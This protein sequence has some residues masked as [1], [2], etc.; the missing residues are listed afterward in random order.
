[1]FNR[2]ILNRIYPEVNN[3]LRPNQNGFRSRHTTVGHILALRRIIE[4]VKA[5]NLPAILTFV[6]F[7]KAF[8]TIHRGKMLQILIAYGIPQQLVDA[9]EILYRNTQAKV[10]S[11]DGETDIF[12][13]QA[14]V[15]QGDTLAPFIFIIVL[16][17]ALRE[18]T[19]GKEEELGFQ[20]MKRKSKRHGPECITDLDF[21][22]DISLLSES[23]NQAQ[24]LLTRLEV[25]SAKVGLHLNAAKT[26][27]IAYNQVD[28]VNIK[29][30]D[31]TT[32]D[33]TDDFKYLGSYVDSTVKEIN[34]RKAQAWTACHQLRKIWNSKMSKRLKL[35]LFTAAVESVLLYGCE[36]W[37]LNKTIEKKLDGTYTRMLRMVL[38]IHWNEH[39]TNEELYGDMPKISH[40]IRERRLRFVGHC[41]R[42]ND[43][44]VSKLVLWEP[45]HG[46]SKRGRP[47]T[48]YLDTLREDTGI[49]SCSEIKAV[50]MD[51]NI[52]RGFVHQVRVGT[53]PK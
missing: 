14:G 8:D 22:D 25:S 29:S 6:D 38:N 7:K 10:L 12:E 28:E 16:D 4:G 44:I 39:K 45:H 51:R 43:E 53:R 9:I 3:R 52:W 31:G 11:P 37:T 17:Y 30:K 36:A 47:A 33:T 27:I 49:K 19:L 5:K 40:K 50:M 48:T 41:V 13:I 26:K 2:I 42:H 24:E 1:M 32:I 18:A 46:Y 35:N 23:I 20:I 21:A 34:V 15:L